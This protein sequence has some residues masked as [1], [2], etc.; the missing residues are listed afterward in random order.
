MKSPRWF[1][2]L[3][4][5]ASLA[6]CTSPSRRLDPQV[7]AQIQESI[8]TRADVDKL[9][10][11][12]LSLVTAANGRTLAIYEV[13]ALKTRGLLGP[14]QLHARRLSLLYDSRFVVE[15]KLLSESATRYRQGWQDR[16]GQPLPRDQII[17]ALQPQVTRTDLVAKFG[18]PTV[19][20]LT[21]DGDTVAGWVALQTASDVPSGVRE[22]IVEVVFDPNNV[23]RDYRIVGV[24]EPPRPKP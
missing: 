12:P 20:S 6:G 14:T 4:V 5:L 19:E 13:A 10:G 3:S 16:L 11:H 8:S 2:L 7:V 23:I 24:L 17:Q 9:L 21:L 18:P 1:L 22:Q 15:R